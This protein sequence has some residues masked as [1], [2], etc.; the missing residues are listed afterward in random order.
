MP[1]ERRNFIVIEVLLGILAI[2][3]AVMLVRGNVTP[4]MKKIAVIL[5]DSEGEEWNALKHAGF[6]WNGSF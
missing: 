2:F 6:R 4:K 3:C 1:T 5:D